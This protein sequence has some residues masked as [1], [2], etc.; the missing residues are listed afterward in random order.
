MSAELEA[1]IARLEQH[2]RIKVKCADCDGTGEIHPQPYC[3]LCYASFDADTLREQP[4]GAELLPCG[5]KWFEKDYVSGRTHFNLIDTDGCA[6]CE[7]DGW[8]SR[9]LSEIPLPEVAALGGAS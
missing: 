9:A 5:H 2:I 4:P 6:E 8:V 1:R 3:R 7:G